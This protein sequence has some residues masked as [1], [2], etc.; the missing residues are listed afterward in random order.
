MIR[1]LLFLFLFFLQVVIILMA[2][3]LLL[4][5]DALPRGTEVYETPDGHMYKIKTERNGEET[6]TRDGDDDD[7]QVT[8]AMHKL[9]KWVVLMENDNETCF[10]IDMTEEEITQKATVVDF[11]TLDYE[12]KNTEEEVDVEIKATCEKHG[13]GRAIIQLG[14]KEET[15]TSPKLPF[16][17]GGNGGIVKR[18][19][20]WKICYL[21]VKIC[22][23]PCYVCTPV[24]HVYI[25]WWFCIRKC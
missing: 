14:P 1:R 7:R 5:T 2:V 10:V 22:R 21:G 8:I 3:A 13:T 6:V 11:E 18:S 9:G 15:N 19:T 4:V 16:F 25:R 12:V 23:R 20:C 17:K 24:C